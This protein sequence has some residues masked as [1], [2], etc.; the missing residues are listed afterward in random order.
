MTWSAA[1]LSPAKPAANAP[2]TAIASNR[3]DIALAQV[4][5]M[6]YFRGYSEQEIASDAR[7][8]RHQ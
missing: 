3:R 2:S 8:R 6:R 7:R 4:A 1:A 5:Q